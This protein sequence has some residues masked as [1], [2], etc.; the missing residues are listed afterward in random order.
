MANFLSSL[1]YKIIKFRIYLRNRLRELTDPRYYD[2]Q[3]LEKR[4]HEIS[5]EILEQDINDRINM[6][7]KIQDMVIKKSK[8]EMEEYARLHNEY[9]ETIKAYEQV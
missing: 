5:S 4:I 3:E 8:E 7:V 1:N 6:I 9:N 2:S